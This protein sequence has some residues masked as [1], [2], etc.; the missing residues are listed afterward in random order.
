MPAKMPDTVPVL[1]ARDVCIGPTES[2]DGSRC[3]LVRH[4]ENTFN[5]HVSPRH[6][7][8]KAH[9]ELGTVVARERRTE[10]GFFATNYYDVGRIST[11][12]SAR[13]WNR[14]MGHLGYT[15]GN[16]EGVRGKLKPVK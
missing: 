7:L 15:R 10:Q 14:A 6:A 12:T 4:Y 13:V 8:C 11:R 9:E 16:P 1:T 3:C 5:G 2:E